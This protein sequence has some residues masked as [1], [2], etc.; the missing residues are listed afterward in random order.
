MP[1]LKRVSMEIFRVPWVL[2][3]CQRNL[4]LR[5]PIRELPKSK[6]KGKQDEH[7]S[8]LLIHLAKPL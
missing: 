4:A 2:L 1:R 6:I 3:C 7:I 8:K 5:I